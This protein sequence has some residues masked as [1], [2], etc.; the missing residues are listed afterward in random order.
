MPTD[1]L[2]QRL[3][4]QARDLTNELAGITDENVQPSVSDCRHVQQLLIDLHDTLSV[5]K[6][7]MTEKELSPSFAIHA[8]VSASEPTPEEKNDPVDPPVLRVEVNRDPPQ[9]QKKGKPITIGVNDKFRFINELFAQNAAEYHIAV[10][11][12]NNLGNWAD[13][14]L[15]LAS[16]RN[17]YGWKDNSEAAKHLQLLAKKR[18]T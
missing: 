17:L 18:F 6:H 1:T 8:H 10:E 4:T 13:T 11:Q 9:A 2:L 15:Y 14:E 12:L 7:H 3:K 5:Y 16:L